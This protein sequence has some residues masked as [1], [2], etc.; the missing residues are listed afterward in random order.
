MEYVNPDAELVHQMSKMSKKEL[1]IM[2]KECRKI[3]KETQISDKKRQKE[4]EKKRINK[5][6]LAELFL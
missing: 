5:S 1:K 3:I 4:E 2:L 6:F